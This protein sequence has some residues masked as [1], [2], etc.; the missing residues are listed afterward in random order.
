MIALCV[1]LV[2]LALS[3]GRSQRAMIWF[4]AGVFYSFAVILIALRPYGFTVAHHLPS[5]LVFAYLA[6]LIDILW[7]DLG[8]KSRLWQ[9]LAVAFFCGL[10]R[11]ALIV[12]GPD[13]NGAGAQ[14][15]QTLCLIA[16]TPIIIALA[17]RN[18]QRHASRS[19]LVVAGAAVLILLVNFVRLFALLFGDGRFLLS[20][21]D[22]KA[23]LLIGAHFLAII[24][25]NA[26][27]GGFLVEQSARDGAIARESQK[28]AEERSNELAETVRERDLM[29]LLNSRFAALSSFSFFT[30]AII[31]E[32]TQPLQ[33]L[34]LS[35][36]GLSEEVKGKA[37]LE[38]QTEFVR[39]QTEHCDEI[40]RTLRR[41]MIRGSAG[42]KQVDLANSLRGLLPILQ[43]QM[44]LSGI[45]FE[46]NISDVP[47]FVECND[48]L[49]QRLV[50]NLVA[51]A[52]DALADK[53]NGR[54]VL[55]LHQENGRARMS[56]IDNSGH[57]FDLTNFNLSALAAST[58][59]DGMGV[60]LVLSEMLARQWGGR[61]IL[62]IEQAAEERM[63]VFSLDLPTVISSEGLV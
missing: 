24:F 31:H 26:G 41:I 11:M 8:Q 5:F 21:F 23:T 4:G 33:A 35:V 61:L 42:T 40:V 38:E 18:G 49:F 57:S 44:E 46:G 22:W 39:R 58:K 34:K 54:L 50:F 52:V 20:E 29:I 45:A 15:F 19:M 13:V 48:V 32:L 59:P 30:S 37:R 7:Q 10:I 2:G 1:P 55:A 63:T 9:L 62:T 25:L 14:I 12:D 28:V 60:G 17:W 51:N 43:T 53:E 3:W 6:I 27:Y 56:V 36:S 16:A 47:I